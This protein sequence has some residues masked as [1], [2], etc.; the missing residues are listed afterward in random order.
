MEA[1][2]SRKVLFTR[3]YFHKKTWDHIHDVDY[4]SLSKSS[5]DFISEV[6]F[7]ISRFLAF[8]L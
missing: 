5:N 3:N 8:S 7:Q 2:I 4:R 6:G 1:A